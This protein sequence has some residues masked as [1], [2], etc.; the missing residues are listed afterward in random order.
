[1]PGTRRAIAAMLLAHAG[2]SGVRQRVDGAPPETPAGN[3]D[4]H[5]DNQSRDSVG[6]GIAQR[7]AGKADQHGN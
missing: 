7:D 3:A 5:R 6:E 2:W 1:M 4:E